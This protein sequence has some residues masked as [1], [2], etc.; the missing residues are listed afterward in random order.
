[1]TEP[2]WDDDEVHDRDC[3]T[4]PFQG[5]GTVLNVAGVRTTTTGP[6]KLFSETS[7]RF[8]VFID[9]PGYYSDPVLISV[10]NP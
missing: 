10:E 8:L 5:E 6:L 9:N 1:M 7:K 3:I 2:D 4:I